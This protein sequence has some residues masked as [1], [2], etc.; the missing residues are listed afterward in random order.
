MQIAKG[1]SW[2]GRPLKNM[3]PAELV[4]VIGCMMSR[5]KQASDELSRRTEFMFDLMKAKGRR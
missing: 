5:E 2:M 4:A 1:A 3:S